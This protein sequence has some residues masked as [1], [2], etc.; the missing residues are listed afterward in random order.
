MAHVA[1]PSPLFSYTGGRRAIEVDGFDLASVLD[2][3][4]AKYP[5]LRFR[6][7]DEHGSIRPHVRLWVGTRLAKDLGEPVGPADDVTIVAALSGG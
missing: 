5:G 7:V 2:G 4:E 1:I 6:I 3:L